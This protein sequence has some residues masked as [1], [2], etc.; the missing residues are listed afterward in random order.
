M[1]ED[2]DR[3]RRGVRRG[4]RVDDLGSRR[5]AAAPAPH[6][7]L[8][9]RAWASRRAWRSI[10][11]RRW[12]C[13]RRSPADVD[14][15]LVM[16]VNPGFGGQTFIPRSESKVR[17]V[18]QLLDRAGNR[19][20]IE[21]DGGIDSSN[22]GRIVAAGASIL[23][24]G[25]ADFR[26]RRRRARDP[27]AARIGHAEG[28]SDR[29]PQPWNRC[30]TSRSVVRVRYAETDKMGVVYYANY[31]VWFEVAR[32][33]LLR[34]LGWSYREMESA[35]VSLP[36][37]EAHCDYQRPARYDDEL[38]ITTDGT[39]AVAGSHGVHCTKCA[40]ADGVAVAASGRTCTPRWTR[41]AGR[42]GCR[43]ASA[44]C[45]HEGAGH[46]R[47]RL[48]RVAPDD[49]AA[50]SR[51]ARSSAST[52]SPTTTRARSRRATSR[53][54]PAGRAS[55]SSRAASST[56]TCRRCSTAR[57]TCSISPR[58]P[59]CARAGAATSGSTPTT[60]STRRS[61][62][63]RPASAGRSSA[64]STRRA[65]R[66]YGDNVSIPMRE[67]AL[68]QPVSP[69]GV[70]KLAAEQLCHLYCREPRR[71]GDLGALLHGVRPA[72]AAGHGVHIASSGGADRS[73]DH[74]VWRRRADARLHVRDRRRRGDDCRRRRA[75]CRAAPTTSAAAR[76]CRSITCWTS[77]GGWPASR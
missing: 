67:D 13:S 53:S 24:A 55:G 41:A 49:G 26:L 45:S 34:S 54:M 42:A 17:A 38:E 37:I 16:S 11:R 31:F 43:R 73:A 21:V 20:P 58:R 51:R 9:S 50:R 57:R 5:G 35:G 33:D 68:P 52:A 63:S 77:S 28:C 71:A 36:V 47:R 8:R 1:I 76:G 23:V 7:A 6:A 15:V 2:P 25:S 39:A 64:S 27:A 65:R 3:Y 29:M 48:H 30:P 22:A 40:A 70:T 69:Y 18:R 32:A 75:A 4:R 74:A 72:A 62:C 56:P 12:S 10:R 14:H 59:A 46:R 61:G 44:R 19:A 60:T 66:V